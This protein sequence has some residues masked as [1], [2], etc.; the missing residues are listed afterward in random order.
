M[1]DI[2]VIGG[3]ISGL[4]VAAEAAAL[5]FSV[6]LFERAQFSGATSAHSLRIIHGGLRYL[7]QFDIPRLLESAQ[8]QQDILSRYPQHVSPL[9]CVTPLTR[10][11]LKSRFPMMIAA[12]VYRTLT[13]RFAK[14][15][16]TPRLL[17]LE[18]LRR[19]VPVLANR[20]P[21]GAFSWWDALVGDPASFAAEIAREARGAGAVLH[22]QCSV[23][24][25][26][27]EGNG[28]RLDID[29]AGGTDRVSSRC[30]V[31]ATGPWLHR[32]MYDR[33][34]QEPKQLSWC[35]AFNVLLRTRLDP[36]H[37]IGIE[38]DEKRLYFAVPRG[39]QG[40]LGTGYL[41]FEGAP[42]TASISEREVRAF[43]ESFNRAWPEAGVSMHDV[44]G[45]ECGVLPA[46]GMGPRGPE[47]L[48]REEL[49][50]AHGYISVVSTKY[51]TFRMQAKAVLRMASAHLR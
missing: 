20:A 1:I 16:P 15:A 24:S 9:P 33:P 48:G 11:G 46:H 44:V 38:S 39:E 2:A 27:R 4:G 35:R 14:G 41:P 50:D 10:G 12:Y 8:A 32:V 37:G 51:T 42:E 23:S 45:V 22:E 26:H 5:G 29:G 31:D 17:G 49:Y 13:E 3:G 34:L 28:F 18:E 40:V 47:L 7:Q 21:F 19:E 6:S 30:V 43:L 25:V 36:R